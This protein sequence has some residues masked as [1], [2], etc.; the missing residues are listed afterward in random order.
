MKFRNLVLK[1]KTKT[2]EDN[3][4]VS[5]IESKGKTQFFYQTNII[6]DRIFKNSNEPFFS[7]GGRGELAGS[8]G[9]RPARTGRV[10]LLGGAADSRRRRR[11][12]Q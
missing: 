9:R 4:K 1:L 7:Q 5:A 3:N 2:F 11:R 6:R 10:W 8:D 12:R